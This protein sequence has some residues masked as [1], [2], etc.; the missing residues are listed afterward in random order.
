MASYFHHT[1][2]QMGGTI[3]YTSGTDVWSCGIR[4]VEITGPGPF[5]DPAGY[6]ADIKTPLAT[7]FHAAGNK[8]QAS[9]S[10]DFLKVNNID[11]FGHYTDTTNTNRT[12]Y[13]PVILGGTT[14]AVPLESC[15]VWTWETGRARGPAH[16]GRIYPPNSYSLSNGEMASAER[17]AQANAG[18]AL[19]AVLQAGDT[20]S[21]TCQP[22]VFSSSS[23]VWFPITGVSV[24]SLPDRQSR[25]ENKIKGARTLV[26]I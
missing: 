16:R 26:A 4:C 22:G 20:G 12:D 7:W 23:S 21:G 8:I 25:R 1:L 5:P 2:V 6:M 11:E 14:Q 18:K 10:L 19:L 24:D 17:T 15:C 13:S 3:T 9:S